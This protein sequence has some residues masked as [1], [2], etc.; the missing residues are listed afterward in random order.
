MDWVRCETSLLPGMNVTE[1]SLGTMLEWP[2]GLFWSLGQFWNQTTGKTPKI[3]GTL[4]DTA[5][6]ASP[7]L[8]GSR[9]NRGREASSKNLLSSSVR[10]RAVTSWRY[11][12]SLNCSERALRRRR[13]CV[14]VP[15]NCVVSLPTFRHV[16]LTC[17][18]GLHKRKVTREPFP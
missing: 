5:A 1:T 2:F 11:R 7:D 14:F 9:N 15:N 16:Y 3:G 8:K 10:T 12:N 4:V 6:V 13:V 18:P 17:Q